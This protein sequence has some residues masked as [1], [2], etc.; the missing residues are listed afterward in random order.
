[1]RNKL[2]TLILLA[3]LPLFVVKPALAG[4]GVSP[5]EIYNDSL[6]PGAKFEK[7]IVLSRS[8]ANENLKVII[9]TEMG[10]A[11][12]W[13]KFDLGKEFVFPKGQQRQIVKAT[14]NVPT[15]ADLKNYKGFIRIKA[16][17]MDSSVSGVSIIQGARME[18]SFITTS[19]NV[20]L[21]NIKGLNIPDVDF[22]KPI[23][24]LLNIQNNGNTKTAPSKVILE[25][26]DLN[27]NPVATLETTKL[28]K[29]DPNT[30]KEITAEFENKLNGG[31]YFGIVKAYLEDKLIRSDRLVFKVGNP[32]EGYKAPTITK[33]GFFSGLISS[34]KDNK[35]EI[36]FFF[37]IPLVPIAV[38]YILHKKS[39][40][41][42]V[43]KIFKIATIAYAIIAFT[44]LFFYHQHRLNDIAH[45]GDK[46]KVE[47]E[48]IE[49]APTEVSK[50]KVQS[51]L[52]VDK[53]ASAYP[54][55]RIPDTKSNVV[56]TATE[57]EKLSV[58]EEIDGWYR[59]S[60]GNGTGGWLPKS[61][62]KQTQ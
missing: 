33:V 1:M 45:P 3:L 56:Y 48:T 39:K 30:T 12:S 32:P 20:D 43:K 37:L 41:K 2:L 57:N 47:G 21:L 17:S 29:I 42:K 24:L 23:K 7:E 60:T 6:K 59:V 18:V 10:E 5:A 44:L 46:G 14:V 58:L 9:E 28:E 40:S 36:I 50:P 11:E 25:V 8:D 51:S 15:N 27:K 26:Q 62:V 4:F 31:E 52:V 54:I 22:Q 49:I 61:S 16:S 53:K 13:I 38:G 19:M 34:I 35:V 55:Y